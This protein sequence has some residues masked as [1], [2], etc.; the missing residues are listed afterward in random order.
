MSESGED[1]PEYRYFLCS[2]FIL[3]PLYASCGL[4]RFYRKRS[5]YNRT[6]SCM[7]KVY[8]DWSLL[9]TIYLPPDL[10]W[11][12]W[13][14]CVDGISFEIACANP[15]CDLTCWIVTRLFFSAFWSTL[16]SEVLIVFISV[17]WL[18][19]D[20]F[21]QRSRRDVLSDM[22]DLPIHDDSS[23][24]EQV[25]ILAFSYANGNCLHNKSPRILPCVS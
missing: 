12:G 14:N 24:R 4:S 2:W 21:T 1:F 17:F 16:H 20:L 13:K 23:T 22:S 25:H 15:Q 18:R 7:M 19:W 6:R 11:T 8:I 9:N 5:H 10:Y 3:L